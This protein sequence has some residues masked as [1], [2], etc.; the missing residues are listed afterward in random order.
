MDHRQLIIVPFDMVVGWFADAEELAHL[1]LRKAQAH[2]TLL[3]QLMACDHHKIPDGSGGRVWPIAI[4]TR[5][6]PSGAF[7]NTTRLVSVRKGPPIGVM[8]TRQTSPHSALSVKN[9]RLNSHRSGNKVLSA[10]QHSAMNGDSSWTD[11]S[12][13]GIRGGHSPGTSVR[14]FRA[15]SARPHVRLLTTAWGDDGRPFVGERHDTSKPGPQ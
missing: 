13:A 4:S 12:A 6:A 1:P 11:S 9:G 14:A 8:S 5:R 15:A 10:D 3:D 2:P 7:Q